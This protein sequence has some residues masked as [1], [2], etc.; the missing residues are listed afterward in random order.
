MVRRKWELG[1][2]KDYEELVM[3]LLNP[4]KQHYSENGARLELGSGGAVY[5]QDAVWAEAFLRPLW[6]LVP[7]W[8]GG[9]KTPEFE[10]IYRRGLAVGTDPAG[11]EYWGGFHDI[12][13]RFVE[14]AS[15]AY[16]ILMVPE[17]LWDPLEP[18]EKSRLAVWLDGINH[19]RCP[20]CNWMFFGILVNIAL[21]SK[22]MAY[23]RER[24]TEY[25]DYIES[26][27]QGD[28]WYIDGQNGEK[29]YYV[30]FAFHYYSLIYVRFM[31]HED[32]PRCTEYQHRATVFAGEFLTWFD[33][34][35]SALAYGRSLTYRMAQVAF[36]S[37]CVSCELE[38]LPYPVMKGVIARHLRFWMKLPVFDNGNVLT[39]GYGYANLLMSE[40]YN[41]PGSPYWCMKAFA[42]LSLP[43]GHPF[44][45]LEEALLPKLPDVCLIAN[46]DMLVQRLQGQVNA[47]VT[48]RTLPHHHVHT[49]EKY[50][51]FLYS[52][53][54]AFSVPRSM[55][56]LEEAAP[57]N[58]LAV[59]LDE[60]VHIKGITKNAVAD[61][62]GIY[63]E[64]SPCMG[65][66]IA[67][68]II[69]LPDGH[70][71]IHTVK[72]SRS[73]VAYDCGYALPTA[74]EDG[75][76]EGSELSFKHGSLEQYVLNSL[77]GGGERIV[78]CASPNTNLLHQRT[79][80]PAM[81]YP[82]E[83][84]KQVLIT[85]FLLSQPGQNVETI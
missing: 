39:V 50:S 80:I 36:F 70:R 53:R 64:W 52:S 19:H 4:L 27:Y 59:V 38:V 58:M 35:G 72:S 32:G 67:T 29:D 10:M 61:W 82:I 45:T 21:K 8:A 75:W 42:L 84:G 76:I 2:R 41:A 37:M 25:L 62:Q 28:G 56:S 26:C 46:G 33:P 66:E 15:I 31:K 5:D 74:T 55:N 85:E 51:K 34:D 68:Q 81:R 17:V 65:I 63:L 24:L 47:Y 9:S 12:D 30:S 20:P 43:E 79:V 3:E 60:K 54:Y 18:D 13:Q 14:M 44:W 78:I 7:L 83:P 40:Q 77:R 1:S 16:G 49:E 69:I 48:G 71:R 11:D 23:C 6:G 57:D 22:G 73:G